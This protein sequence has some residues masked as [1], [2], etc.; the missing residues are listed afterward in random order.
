ME[1]GHKAFGNE[2][3]ITGNINVDIKNIH[4]AVNEIATTIN[5]IWTN[6]TN[7]SDTTQ[8]NVDGLSK[9]VV[10]L[11]KMQDKLT[12]KLNRKPIF[13]WVS[14]ASALISIIAL[15]GAF[16][17]KDTV[18]NEESIVLITVGI[19]ATFVVVSNYMQVLEIKRE[20]EMKVGGVESKMNVFRSEFAE[21]IADIKGELAKLS[22]GAKDNYDTKLPPDVIQQTTLTPPL[23][24][25]EVISAQ[26]PARLE[27]L[28]V[29]V[30]RAANAYN[31]RIEGKIILAFTDTN[32]D[33]KVMKQLKDSTKYADFRYLLVSK[34]GGI[35]NSGF[36]REW[37]KSVTKEAFL[38]RM[39]S[40]EVWKEMQE[41]ERITM[42]SHAY[43][44]VH[45]LP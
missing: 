25:V 45:R 12:Q 15:C 29:E 33:D 42:F 1:I 8:K 26:T 11:R 38:V 7:L 43:E 5:E 18:I 19:L 24:Y 17:Y 31:T 6:I 28:A 44:I 32:V 4:S 21:K 34:G 39:I 10:D 3:P 16:V 30:A 14:V 41:T 27:S 23:A 22:Q 13:F 36:N 35:N 37:V 9:E 20:F 40:S 2:S